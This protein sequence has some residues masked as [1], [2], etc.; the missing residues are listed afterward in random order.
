MTVAVL[1][2]VFEGVCVFVGVEVAD[3]VTVGV[4]VMRVG[5]TGPCNTSVGAPCELLP[6][7][8]D[9]TETMSNRQNIKRRRKFKIPTP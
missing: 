3:G 5:T 9:K 1:V 6:P 4:R 2:G 7:Q 8:A